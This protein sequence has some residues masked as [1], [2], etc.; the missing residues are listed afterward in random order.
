MHWGI[1]LVRDS[2]PKRGLGL[3][4]ETGCTGTSYG[5]PGRNMFLFI[6]VLVGVEI[7]VRFSWKDLSLEKR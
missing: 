6:T 3:W 4:Y 5:E 2:H 1:E 7:A